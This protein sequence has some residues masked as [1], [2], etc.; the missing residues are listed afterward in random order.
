MTSLGSHF[1]VIRFLC[2]CFCDSSVWNNIFLSGDFCWCGFLCCGFL[3]WFFCGCLMAFS[4]VLSIDFFVIGAFIIVFSR[5][6]ATTS[7]A[8]DS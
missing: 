3:C 5:T 7:S 4:I 8:I 2:C 6:S 1:F